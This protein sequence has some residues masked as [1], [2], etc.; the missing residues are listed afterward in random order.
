MLESASLCLSARFVIFLG[1]KTLRAY[2]GVLLWRVVCFEL[3][4]GVIIWAWAGF[5]MF[6]RLS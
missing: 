3:M 1:L 4:D 2:A 5:F 6:V